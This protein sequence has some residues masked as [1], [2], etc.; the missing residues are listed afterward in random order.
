MHR[1]PP[2]KSGDWTERAEAFAQ[3]R[4]SLDHAL[5]SSQQ[6]REAREQQV[7]ALAAESL[8]QREA[9]PR[10]YRRKGLSLDAYYF[11]IDL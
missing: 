3:T 6:A 4:A 8:R 10:F 9:A 2:S 1:R 7:T 11:S 5:A